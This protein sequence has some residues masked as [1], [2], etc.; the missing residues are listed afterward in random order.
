MSEDDG[1]TWPRS[2]VQ[3]PGAFAY[4]CLTRLPSD[5]VGCLYEGAKQE[6]KLVTLDLAELQ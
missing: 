5:R 4:S 6:I 1:R 3:E 2:L